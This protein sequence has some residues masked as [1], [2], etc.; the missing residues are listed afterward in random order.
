MCIHIHIYIYIHI[1][2]DHNLPDFSSPASRKQRGDGQPNGRITNIYIY[3]YIC[4]HTHMG[5]I[6]VSGA[7]THTHIDSGN[8]YCSENNPNP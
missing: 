1:Y 6:Q 2:T 8:N 4:T 5:C 7:H 3:I